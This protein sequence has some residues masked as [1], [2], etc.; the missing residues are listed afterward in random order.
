[1]RMQHY[2]D[3]LNIDKALPINCSLPRWHL[4]ISIRRNQFNWF[5]LH[6]FIDRMARWLRKYGLRVVPRMGLSFDSRFKRC[7]RIDMYVC[8]SE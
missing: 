3:Y 8:R 4:Q 1:M 5:Q 2:V 7:D 6:F